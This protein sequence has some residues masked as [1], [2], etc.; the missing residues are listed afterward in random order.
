V[1]EHATGPHKGYLL[2]LVRAAANSTTARA[3]D[4]EVVAVDNQGRFQS[5]IPGRRTEAA[6]TLVTGVDVLRT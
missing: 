5:F 6:A 3:T 2:A 4:D 1:T